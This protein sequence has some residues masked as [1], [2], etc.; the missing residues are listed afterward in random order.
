MEAREIS[1]LERVECAEVFRG[2]TNWLTGND[3]RGL[4]RGRGA[5][6]ATGGR[7]DI[8]LRVRSAKVWVRLIGSGA[9]SSPDEGRSGGRRTIGGEG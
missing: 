5:S 7:R 8:D 9:G 1:P 6:W 3:G 4:R 2:V